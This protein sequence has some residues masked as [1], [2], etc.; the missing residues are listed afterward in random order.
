MESNIDVDGVIWNE[1]IHDATKRKTTTGKWQKKCGVHK[2]LVTKVL[3]EQSRKKTT[4]IRD[5]Y[6][7]PVSKSLLARIFR[8]DKR[9]VG[10]RLVS[11]QPTGEELGYPVYDLAEAARYLVAP[12]D[13]QVVR[14]IEQ[15][16]SNKLP[17]K[18]RKEFWDAKNAQMKYKKDAG[19]L[20]HTQDVYDVFIEVFKTMRTSVMLFADNIDRETGLDDKQRDV[21]N[22]QVD[23]LLEGVRDSL[24]N[25]DELNS[26][27]NVLFDDEDMSSG[28]FDEGDTEHE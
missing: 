13:D 11:C 3:N 25:N 12:P 1:L 23:E 21:L 16:K 5:A 10:G 15:M 4:T 20:W 26:K 28:I 8:I 24:L 14:V 17:P 22:R 6:I 7:K 9:E 27:V 2:G 19:E 18:L